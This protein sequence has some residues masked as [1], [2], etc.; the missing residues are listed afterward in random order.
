VWV[1]VLAAAAAAGL[2]VMAGQG[3]TVEEDH[4][5]R[6]LLGDSAVKEDA[7]TVVQHHSADSEEAVLG[8]VAGVRL[9]VAEELGLGVAYSAVDLCSFQTVV[10]DLLPLVPVAAGSA[11][12]VDHHHRWLPLPEMRRRSP[13][14][15]DLSHHSARPDSP[16]D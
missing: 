10:V 15:S 3:V 1:G 2:P 16:C 7:E 5:A 8:L 6:A 11:L 14:S 12:S 4:L 13:L 9:V